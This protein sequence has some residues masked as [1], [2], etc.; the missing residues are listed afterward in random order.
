MATIIL[1][2]PRTVSVTRSRHVFPNRS[3][4]HANERVAV[5]PRA[6]GHRSSYAGVVGRVVCAAVVTW[7]MAV[8]DVSM[9][10]TADLG[11]ES[12]IRNTTRS[13][14][15]GNTASPTSPEL[16][17]A[18]G[19]NVTPDSREST[20]FEK[21]NDQGVWLGS[22]LD[23]GTEQTN[24]S[25]KDADQCNEQNGA[26]LSLRGACYGSNSSNA[27]YTV[28]WDWVWTGITIS[29]ASASA[30]VEKIVIQYNVD[31]NYIDDIHWYVEN[32]SYW[33]SPYYIMPKTGDD[34]LDGY[35]ETSEK[36]YTIYPDT[37]TPVNGN[38]YFNIEDTYDDSD[39]DWNMGRIDW[40]NIT[41]Y[42]IDPETVSTPDTP[43]G[44]SDGETGD[45]LWFSTGGSS[46][47]WGD[48]VEYR[49]NW[50]DGS[51]YSSWGSATRSHT[52]SNPDDFCV[53]AQA[54]C[55]T[56]TSVTSSWSNCKNVEIQ[57]PRWG[58]I[59]AVGPS[60]FTG[61]ART[62][63]VSVRNRGRDDNNLIVHW[64]SKPSGWSI[65]PGDRQTIVPYNT[66]NSTFF[67][68]TVT[69]PSYDSTGTI[70]WEL[71]YDE[72]PSNYLLDTV[73]QP[74]TN[75]VPETVSTPDTPSGPSD[76]ETGDS[77]WFSTGGSSSSWGDSVEYRFN[78]GDGSGYSSWGSATRSHT[79]S[80]PDDFCVQAQA[81]CQTHTSV[82]SSWSNCKNVEI[83]RPR[84][85]EIVAVGPSEF[86]GSARTV[87]VSVRNRG[88]D[89][90]NLIV[91]WTSKPSGWSISPGDRQTIV[92]YN[93]T[94][95]TFFTFT[96]TPPSYDS[97][98]TI[99]WELLYDEW[100]SNYL[101]DTV[102][103]PVTNTAPL[104]TV[105]ATLMTQD[106][107]TSA[108]DAGTRFLLYTSPLGDISGN[109]PATFDGVPQ[110]TYLLEGYYTGTFFG[111]EFWTSEPSV[112]VNAGLP[113][114]VTLT[115]NTP[116]A[117]NVEFREG[118]SSGPLIAPG[119][120]I[121]AGTVV[122]VGVTLRNNVPGT[123]LDSQVRLV[124]DR[125]QTLPHDFDQVSS[126]QSIAGS[127]G[128]HLYTFTFTPTSEGQ[129]YYALDVAT[130]LTNGNTV[131]TDSWT[132]TQAMLVLPNPCDSITSMSNGVPETGTL[133][134]Q[135][136]WTTYND[137]ARGEL[138]GERV[139]EFTSTV[140]GTYTLTASEFSGNPD[141]YLLSA[142]DKTST[143]LLGHCWEGGSEI[144]ELAANTKYY[145]VVDNQS[146]SSS[147]SY[148]IQV[149]YPMEPPDIHIER[150][151][152]SKNTCKATGV[153][154]AIAWP[155]PDFG[156][157]VYVEAEVAS[158][159]KRKAS[160]AKLVFLVFHN[161]A[162][163]LAG[164]LTRQQDSIAG[165]LRAL[166]MKLAGSFVTTHIY[167]TIPIVA[168]YLTEAGLEQCRD[169][170][171]VDAILPADG[172]V[173]GYLGES[174]PL[175][176][177]DGVEDSLG[178]TGAGVT[179]A[180]IDSGIDYNH[181]D[182]G[183]G[184]GPD[185]RIGGGYDFVDDDNDPIDEHGHGTNVAGIVASSDDTFRGI[186]PAADL[187]AVRVLDGSNSGNFADLVSGI[188]WCRSHREEFDISIMNLSIG[189]GLEHNSANLC[190]ATAVGIAITAARN[191]G[192]IAI[193]ASGNDNY[194]DGIGLPACVTGAVAVGAVYDSDLGREPDFGTYTC[195]CS[196][197]TTTANA[198]PCFTNTDEL[199]DV[200]APGA[201][202]TAPARGG[203]YVWMSG[204]SQATPHVAGVAALL[205]EAN[206]VLTPDLIEDALVGMTQTVN[207]PRSGLD[208][209]LLNALEAVSG[210]VQ[211]FTISNQGE[212]SLEV[213][214]IGVDNGS[215]WLSVTPPPPYSIPA[216]ASQV[217]T[218]LIDDSC[219]GTGTYEDRLVVYSNDPDESPYPD[220][221][222]VNLTVDSNPTPTITPTPGDTVCEG[223]TVTLDAGAD[224][225]SYLWSVGG[226]TT[227]TID[228][229]DSDIYSV[230]VTNAVGCE[231]SDSIVITVN[232]L[233][234]IPANAMADPQEVCE[235][236]LSMLSASVEG[237]EID[238]YT[239]SCDDAFIGTANTLVVE[240]SSTT[241]Y[242]ARSYDASSDCVSAGCDEVTV[243]VI[244]DG[245]AC[246]DQSYTLCDN[247][248]TCSSGVCQDN[249]ELDGTECNDDDSCT[250][251]DECFGG[252]CV[253]TLET[254]RPAVLWTSPNDSVIHYEG[255]AAN[256]IEIVFSEDVRGP[257][258]IPL[259][260]EDF[261]VNGSLVA[262]TGFDYD[263]VS[264]VV[265]LA[266]LDLADVAWHTI[267]V[268][269]AIEDVCGNK[270]VGNTSGGLP[271]EDDYWIDIGVLCAD[272][273]QDGD[274]DVFDRTQ[275]LAAWTDQNGDVGN[276]LSADY[277]CDGDV[278][279]FDR[280]QFL[281][282]WTDANG[283]DI[284]RPPEH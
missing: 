141:F 6:S 103:Q 98:G 146:D 171:L 122:W 66:T 132:W 206:A 149:D 211:S 7:I 148:T 215:C 208:F 78:W 156:D 41:V 63:T 241:E 95:S 59:V 155:Y 39:P 82:T 96:V 56:H 232:A 239:G 154:E 281:A 44:P 11:Q 238:W 267:W 247:P 89:D 172:H 83:Q 74:V 100:P 233:P 201:R 117:E 72:W 127:G 62:V 237:A 107:A 97:T 179:V 73:N 202:I 21:D 192:I 260:I 240:P 284:G 75:T 168:G 116:Y 205:L 126:F 67:T 25:L 222:Y 58:E 184:F 199:L 119:M 109:N 43:S 18:E 177:G 14:T 178:L 120:P 13:S 70:V 113:T 176:D 140:A 130:E 280:T 246:G 29:C 236:S 253:G 34:W 86:T 270:L 55:Q 250:I 45:S 197:E 87:T 121:A 196:D 36:T 35:D 279:V 54:R 142:C 266:F 106:G 22:P 161:Y 139:Y 48:S 245:G 167:D 158:H 147:A 243:T 57:R 114:N 198:I 3:S 216:G 15:P 61:S 24:V 12:S 134:V 282:C 173:Y 80:N 33:E 256:S 209:P 111:E 5:R 49:F 170:K 28:A 143:N 2:E 150:T 258:G 185:F 138:G 128:T 32:Y 30:T 92:P 200:V 274:V 26:L 157:D 85:G 118:D 46:S 4:K 77:L 42:Y 214:S 248:N 259:G 1:T 235:G 69:P 277:Q 37:G 79:F 194:D 249:F 17:E 131:R 189:D 227:Q 262:I 255:C 164:D 71:L 153:R 221:V 271:G 204:T 230:T 124:C 102:L 129:L 210:V 135:G 264:H 152:L 123:S 65:S 257:G 276:N 10:Q 108:P 181:E 228:V 225:S 217:V 47:S 27:E 19:N 60:E 175:F 191:D 268:S 213:T 190:D 218:V 261:A 53:Q 251:D 180:I 224:F 160:Q 174:R 136:V 203:G 94:N 38:W 166:R 101:L 9:A 195:G 91:H 187:V 145:W 283:L 165:E 242:Y 16:W 112:V 254:D 182:L 115:R 186:A 31:S 68:F 162:A 263:D 50:G 252:A 23:D 163:L 88:R 133:G 234:P 20:H 193:V 275:F 104:G 229:M 144:V 76:G 110:G 244:S 183:G 272:F 125:D 52:F 90:N 220:G 226:E 273:Q 223:T 99:V 219:V 137:C 265:T 159:F 40:W 8:C 64:T 84:W 51:G 269:G 105:V 169:D 212:Q 93:T 207:D 231:G 151:S 278:D 188:N 81:R